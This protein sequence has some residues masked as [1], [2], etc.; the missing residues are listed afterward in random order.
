MPID[1]GQVALEAD[2]RARAPPPA[3][4]RMP[5]VEARRRAAGEE[6]LVDPHEIMKREMFRDPGGKCGDHFDKSFPCPGDPYGVSDQYVV[7]DSLLAEQAEPY[8]GKFGFN[9]NREQ[10]GQRKKLGVK[11]KMEQVFQIQLWE[12]YMPLPLIL[13]DI[14]VTSHASLTLSDNAG[15]SDPRTSTNPITGQLSQLAHG[16]RVRLHLTTVGEQGHFDFRSRRH[17]FEFTAEIDGAVGDPNARMKLTPVNSLYTF[18]EPIKDV[19]ELGLQFYGPD[20]PLRFPPDEIRGVTL[21]TDAGSDILLT[22]PA[23]VNDRAVDLTS[24]LVPGDRIFLEGVDI[25][26]GGNA[27]R[28]ISDYLNSKDGLFVGSTITA[29]TLELDPQVN[30]GLGAGATLTSSTTITLRIAKNRMLIPM[31]TRGL[32][33]KF[34]NLIAP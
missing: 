14:D 22:V 9:I 26:V 20:E 30:P 34:T 21:S 29:T 19:A 8:A 1:W 25:S 10:M 18:T 31:R 13:D 3:S 33:Q 4:R 15:V 5:V 7:I 23:T 12:G 11:N 24:L 2:T 28:D 27:R 6:E 16:A 32:V 17:H